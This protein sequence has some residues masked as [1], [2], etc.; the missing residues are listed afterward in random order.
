VGIAAG[1]SGTLPTVGADEANAPASIQTTFPDGFG[2]VVRD[3]AIKAISS[4][5]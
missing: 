5:M 3:T 4:A 1:L 2:T